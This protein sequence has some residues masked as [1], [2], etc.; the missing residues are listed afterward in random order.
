MKHGLVRSDPFEGISTA[1]RANHERFHFVSREDAAKVLAACPDAQWRLIFALARFGGLRCPSEV[2]KLTWGDINWERNLIRVPSP[3]TEHHEGGASR[4]IPLFPE[5]KQPLLDAF[6]E[7]EDGTEWV[8][9]RYRGGNMNLRT[10]LFRIIAK[11]GVEPWPKLFQNL[12]STRET[13][14]VEEFPAHVAC[15]WI[16]NTQPIA[17]KHYLQLTDEHFAKAIAGESKKVAHNAAQKTHA[18]AH[19]ERSER[20]PDDAKTPT[21]VGICEGLHG[22][23]H[24]CINLNA[25][26]AGLEPATCGLEDRRS[27]QLSYRGQKHES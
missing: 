2:L 3:K 5:L 27:I 25:P 7:T 26:R 1:V 4:M 18:T 24:T 13:E 21:K 9:T 10:Q 8:I 20:K 12:R 23:S 19:Q 15:R 17:A 11:A 22:D 14:L 6:D 16:G